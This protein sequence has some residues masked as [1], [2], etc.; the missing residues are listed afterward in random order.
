[1]SSLS[2]PALDVRLRQLAP[3][4]LDVA[5]QCGRGELLAIVG[6]SG[7][8]KSTILRAIAGLL[9]VESGWV[10]CCSDTWLDTEK[11][12][13]RPA[14]QRPVGMVFQSYALFPHMTAEENVK[15][16]LPEDTPDRTAHARQLLA[17]MN[18]SGLEDRRPG[19]LSGGQQQRVAVARALARMPRVMLLDEPFSAVDEMT[20][21]KLQK[22]LLTLRASLDIPFI[23]VT[24]QL[25]EAAILADRLC[26]VHRGKCLQV[27]PTE[28]VM[29]RPN[30]AEAARLVGQRNLFSAQ[31]VSQKPDEG[32][33]EIRWAGRILT[34]AYGETFQLG[35][36]VMWLIPSGRVFLHRR[37]RAQ[38][39]SR[40]RENPVDGVVS[41][42]LPI[43]D[44]VQVTMIPEGE[45]KPLIF[46]LGAH[47]AERNRLAPGEKIRVSLDTQSL[48]LMAH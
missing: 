6:P 7:G 43:G 10:R 31:V 29:L 3:I 45:K 40:A 38:P 17:R 2:P 46:T 9:R 33:T 26:L 12:I 1:M 19:E 41:E 47:V 42:C 36:N 22:E 39:P 25:D 4:A 20:R 30:S 28:Q 18:L 27:G 24:H 14:H 16:A 21:K 48:H 35:Q 34:A 37:D 23:L 5:F 32:V 11:G 44:M 15:I 8:G 13:D